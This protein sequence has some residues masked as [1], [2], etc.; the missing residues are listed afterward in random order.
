MPRLDDS[1]DKTTRGCTVSSEE[2]RR[3]H[4][5]G[6]QIHVVNLSKGG[7]LRIFKRMDAPAPTELQAH[8]ER[9]PGK[10]PNGI[11][12]CRKRVHVP[13]DPSSTRPAGR[14][15]GNPDKQ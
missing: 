9:A 5:H 3:N 14:V 4:L 11:A 13:N 15:D 7:C 2:L 8:G 10:R 6:G 12:E 1:S